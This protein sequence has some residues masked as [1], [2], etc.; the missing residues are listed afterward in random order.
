MDRLAREIESARVLD[1]LAAEDVSVRATISS[2]YRAVSSAA[3]V[4]LSTAAATVTGDIAATELA[5]VAEGDGDVISQLLAVGLLTPVQETEV[6]D[7]RY[8]MHPLIR[9]F[10]REHP[11]DCVARLEAAKR[12]AAGFTQPS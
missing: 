12:Q 10:A 8:A 4:A 3:R 6:T 11:Q 7:E 1:V 2:S 9:A 5:A